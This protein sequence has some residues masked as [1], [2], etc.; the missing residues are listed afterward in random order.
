[1]E[2]NKLKNIMSSNL[3]FLQSNL[4][5]LDFN[6]AYPKEFA[7]LN[8]SIF[9]KQNSNLMA[10]LIYFMLCKFDN[11]INSKF[12]F[13]Y[14]VT[15][16]KELKIF[17]EV[18][19]EE[20]KILLENNSE[21]F[22]ISKT[23][24]DTAS[25]ERLVKL[26]R[27]MSDRVLL[28]EINKSK[29]I[30]E[31]ENTSLNLNKNAINEKLNNLYKSKEYLEWERKALMVKIVIQKN[32]L[33]ENSKQMNTHQNEWKNFA[34]SLE[35]ELQ[36]L[37]KEKVIVQKKYKAFNDKILDTSIFNEISSLDRAP[38]LE[39]HKVFKEMIGELINKLDTKSD[40]INNLDFIDT[41]GQI[42]E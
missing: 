27:D 14:P 35:N 39:N 29:K 37:E 17:K 26:L 13:C 4:Q 38:K 3:G 8:P 7:T 31:K 41:N 33:I 12:A 30:K 34:V 24:L 2:I 25:G 1:M 16:L 15:T 36:E 9:N 40:F 20:I 21:S 32:K 10:T 5:L 22:L 42:Y 28:N 18:A 19:F 23:I 6:V 11:N